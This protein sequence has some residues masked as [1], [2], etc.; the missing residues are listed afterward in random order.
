MWI[1]FLVLSQHGKRGKQK[2]VKTGAPY[3]NRTFLGDFHPGDDP[4]RKSEK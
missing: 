2:L 3:L 1:D 4:T